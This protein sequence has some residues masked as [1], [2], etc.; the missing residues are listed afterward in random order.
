MAC[1]AWKC[2]GDCDSEGNTCAKSERGPSFYAYSPAGSRNIFITLCS[3]PM[4]T[5]AQMGNQRAMILPAEV[6]DEEQSSEEIATRFSEPSQASS[7][8][9]S[10]VLLP[11]LL[12][13]VSLLNNGC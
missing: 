3:K 6:R 13:Y 9:L 11:W 5:N 8:S 7:T 10:R 2:R 4:T 1:F 12:P